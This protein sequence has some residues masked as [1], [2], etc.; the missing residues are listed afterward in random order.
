M[1]HSPES[2]PRLTVTHTLRRSIIYKVSSNSGNNLFSMKLIKQPHI[3]KT[4]LKLSKIFLKIK[5][6]LSISQSFPYRIQKK[7]HTPSTFKQRK[8]KYFTHSKS[9]QK[10]SRVRRT[11]LAKSQTN[12]KNGERIMNMDSK[13]MNSW[14][15]T[16]DK[17]LK[18]NKK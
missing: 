18:G 11:F 13:V 7:P 6:T 8:M 4:K 9:E 3:F 2:Q 16:T 5:E 14:F 12:F 10:Q 1:Q 15:K 17:S